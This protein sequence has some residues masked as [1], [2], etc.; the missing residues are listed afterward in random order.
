MPPG[1]SPV[2]EK[3]TERVEKILSRM[4]QL[5]DGAQVTMLVQDWRSIGRCGETCDFRGSQ[6]LCA[7]KIYRR[8][9]GPTRFIAVRKS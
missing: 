2:F 6:P 7:Y 5:G 1:H 4:L 9:L 3:K 8:T